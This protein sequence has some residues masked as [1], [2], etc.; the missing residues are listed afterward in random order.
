MVIKGIDVR[1][2][3]KKMAV[4]KELGDYNFNFKFTDEM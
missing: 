1:E 2:I 3:V 4:D